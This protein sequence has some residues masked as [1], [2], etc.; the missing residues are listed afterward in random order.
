MKLSMTK[1]SAAFALAIAVS[2][3]PVAAQKGHG[4]GGGHG[5]GH[6]KDHP[7]QTVVRTAPARTVTRARTE[8]RSSQ[9][10]HR[11][12]TRRAATTTRSAP[13]G[14]CQGRGNPHNTA[15]NCGYRTDRAYRDSHGVWRDR[16]G[17]RLTNGNVYRDRTGTVRDWLGRL[18]R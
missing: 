2:A 5:N 11:T 18:L 1:I 13:P 12:S 3:S 8:T 7:Q 9:M 4:N 17:N 14:W 10:V 16:Y 6:D 15:A